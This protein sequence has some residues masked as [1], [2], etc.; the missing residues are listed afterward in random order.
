MKLKQKLLLMVLLPVAILATALTVVAG[1][2]LHNSL[3]KENEAQLK[4]AL[5]G[6][7]G[8]VDTFKKDKIDIT[9]FEGDTR[10]KSSIEGVEGTKASEV[11]IEE[12][13]NKGN[14]YF[15]ANVNV[16]GSPYFGYYEPIEG[17]MLFAGKPS[18]D[19]SD[20]IN[21]IIMYLIIGAVIITII[22]IISTY[23]VA[24]RTANKIVKVSRVVD[25]VANGN[26]AHD[27]KTIAGR[28]EIAKMSKSTKEMVDNLR[29]MIQNTASVSQNIMSASEDLK[30]TATTTLSASEEIARAIEDVANNST[31]QAGLVNDLITNT[32]DMQEGIGSIQN[33]VENI[34]DSSNQMN[35]NC[36][37][38]KIKIEA[39]QQNSES[40]NESVI[41]IRDKIK[42]TNAVISKMSEILDA[43]DDVATQTKLLSL[44][45][46]IEAARAGDAGKGFAVVAESIR[47]LSEQTAMEL[48]NI[49]D[50]IKNITSDF[51]ECE[52]S[53]SDVVENNDSGM[54]S[55][56]EVIDSF[57]AVNLSIKETNEKVQDVMKVST[58]IGGKMEE[59]TGQ[60]QRLGEASE[61]NA[62][63]SE[64]V[65][66]SVEELAAL[67]STV[68]NS[69][70]LLTGEA[71]DLIQSLSKFKI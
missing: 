71:E 36:N 34:S 15:D 68:N 52:V 23:F 70:V 62:A 55:I 25:T 65:N 39:T 60:I 6:Y 10:V 66:A 16:A 48:V 1:I 32:E 21:K 67:M 24:A 26:L 17:G 37:E 11:V 61:G 19:V 40:M 30:S 44:N 9:I 59:V 2:L 54:R 56:L 47:G 43:I 13:L 18:A 57:E 46:S 4:A 42:S 7:S 38:M 35:T 64:E 58:Q 27:I 12:V 29:K 22:I 31:K 14:N 28:D 33:Y 3:T 49:N 20:S 45:A 63:A 53:I 41:E 69:A 50:I 51:A 5:H 8:D